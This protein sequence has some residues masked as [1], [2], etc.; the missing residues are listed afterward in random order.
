MLLMIFYVIILE[1]MLI[2]LRRMG[3]CG[4]EGL[5]LMSFGRMKLIYI[6]CKD[7]GWISLVHMGGNV[8]IIID[9]IIPKIK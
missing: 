7:K 1:L 6:W 5:E 9:L 8:L 4:L 3:V 2:F